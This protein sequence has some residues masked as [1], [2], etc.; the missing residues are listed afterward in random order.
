MGLANF[1]RAVSR[2]EHSSDHKYLGAERYCGNFLYSL[3]P[4]CPLTRGRFHHPSE[5][6]P[7][8]GDVLLF[9]HGSKA[10]IFDMVM[11]CQTTHNPCLH[12]LRTSC[13]QH[14]NMIN[15]LL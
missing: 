13:D 8:G 10:M 1:I 11:L 14:R 12:S 15:Y 4:C 2:R 3:S 9:S 7:V 5:P 6:H